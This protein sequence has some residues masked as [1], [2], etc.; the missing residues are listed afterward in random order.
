[1]FGAPFLGG[2]PEH[3]TG[4]HGG[5]DPRFLG[6]DPVT[7][8]LQQESIPYPEFD[9]VSMYDEQLA[10]LEALFAQ[11]PGGL[12]AGPA[13]GGFPGV[14]AFN[15]G[16]DPELARALGSRSMLQLGTGLL[17]EGLSGE[18]NWRVL[19]PLVSKAFESYESGAKDAYGRQRD[20]LSHGI[21]RERAVG[22]LERGKAESMSAAN[23]AAVA[24]AERKQAEE[25]L[26]RRV[27]AADEVLASLPD[28][29]PGVEALDP[30]G[31]IALIETLQKNDAEVRKV[32]QKAEKTFDI[33]LRLAKGKSDI[34][35]GRQ[36]RVAGF[37][38]GL[39]GDKDKDEK[40]RKPTKYADGLSL[41]GIEST[42]DPNSDAA[43]YEENEEAIRTALM[44]EA[45]AVKGMSDP[46][47]Y[48]W[49]LLRVEKASPE[50]IYE[51]APD[52]LKH[53]VLEALHKL[54]RPPQ[55]LPI[56]RL[57]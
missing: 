51:Q 8:G 41:I 5:V 52:H 35:E 15:Q 49:K 56:D 40:E 16:M 26:S 55:L 57:R 46:E 50:D 44:E 27:A 10:R 43:L 28:P 39:K 14:S 23:Q 1:M 11:Q 17:G 38:E 25:E 3:T 7:S 6:Q 29:I 13:P 42:G 24:E 4:Y 12:G 54:G 9:P 20:D 48:V 37:K 31:K 47:R 2:Y 30:E 21:A 32:V 53:Q 36:K 33:D 45:E 22:Q 18:P 19:G 34:E